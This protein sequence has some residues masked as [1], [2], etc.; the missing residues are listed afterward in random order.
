VSWDDDAAPVTPRV[1]PVAT[2][3]PIVTDRPMA[4]GPPSPLLAVAA[5]CVVGSAA[6][7][8]GDGLRGHI[9]GWALGSL[10][11]IGI[12]AAYTSVDSKRA[13]SPRYLPTPGLNRFRSTLIVLGVVSAALH[14]WYAAT[15][16]A[17]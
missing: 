16:L 5:L 2:V 6:A 1:D 9:I 4:E 11:T 8:L 15:L 7:L 12:L 14:A 17:S 3:R 13:E 10:L